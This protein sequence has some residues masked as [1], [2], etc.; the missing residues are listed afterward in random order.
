MRELALRIASALVLAT[1]TLLLA[2]SGAGPFALLVAL[3][4]MVLVWEWGRLVR[5]AEID[6][7]TCVGTVGIWLAVGLA[8][9]GHAS[10]GLLAL[11][12]T[13]LATVLLVPQRVAP[14][15]AVGP[16][17]VGLPA[18]VLVWFRTSL[19]G[20]FEAI[21]FLLLVVWATDTGAYIAGR[22]LGGPKLWASVSPNKTWS[23]LLGGVLAATVTAWLCAGWVASPVPLRAVAVAA[24]LAGVSQLGDL[25]E[26]AV[27][28]AHGVKDAS[29]LIPGHGGFMDR[30]DGLIFAALAAGL[31][32]ALLAP[33]APA[34]ALLGLR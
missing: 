19:P 23:G 5:R 31:Y 28:R 16:L 12:V 33:M 4:A 20:G 22:G 11:V 24:L 21:L 18:M 10:V 15:S 26:S 1:A 32:V 17:Y 25:F 8:V 27:K 29:R 9:T 30:V 13:A 2:A 6:A 3:V 14:L 7:A 34:T